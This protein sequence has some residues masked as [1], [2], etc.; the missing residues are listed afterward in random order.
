MKRI[1]NSMIGH[2]RILVSYLCGVR[3]Y[4]GTLDPELTELP[5]GLL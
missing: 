1:A 5:K 4:A 2:N 3:N